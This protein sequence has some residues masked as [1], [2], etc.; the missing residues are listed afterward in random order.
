MNVCLILFP[1]LGLVSGEYIPGT[2]GGS[3]N[4]NELLVVRA[5]L[6]SLMIDDRAKELYT[7]VP[8]NERPK[9][10]ELDEKWMKKGFQFFPAKLLR[11]AFHDCVK[12]TDGTGGCDGCLN[13]EGM[14]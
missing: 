6:W 5:K 14:N 13:W 7:K 8:S 10:D 2:P 3:W 11:L 1:L 4:E 12:Y 9:A